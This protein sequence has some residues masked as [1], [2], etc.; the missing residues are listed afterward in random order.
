MSNCNFCAIDFETACY[1]RASACAVGLVKVREGQISET[2][3][4][5]IKPPEG[6][7]IIPSFTR[8]HGI[9]NKDVTN[10][11]SFEQVWP[12]MK[13]FIGDD[14]L[15]AHNSSFDRSVLRYCLGYYGI[16]CTVPDFVCTVQCAR[17]KWPQLCNHKLDTVS[18]Y[19][20]IELTHHEALSDS[21][22][23]AKIYLEALA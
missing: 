5:L 16:D 17:R 23:C 8:I 18:E 14:F 13:E 6:M 4:T 1:Q 22:A 21:I 15:V 19:L 2:F 11:P 10:A 7:D 20:H 3:Y 9:R 12:K